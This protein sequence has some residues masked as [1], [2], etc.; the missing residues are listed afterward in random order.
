MSEKEFGVIGGTR[1]G[2]FLDV[3][4]VATGCTS[5]LITCQG[6]IVYPQ[7]LS[8]RGTDYLPPSGDG[9]GDGSC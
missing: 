3:D 4:P 2:F 6:E 9:G 1:D 5:F 7:Q 8:V